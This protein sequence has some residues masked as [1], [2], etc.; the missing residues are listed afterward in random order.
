MPKSSRKKDSTRL[1]SEEAHER[2]IDRLNA[3][4][5]QLSVELA[6]MRFAQVEATALQGTVITMDDALDG[7]FE[8]PWD[9]RAERHPS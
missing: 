9:R 5:A 1:V 4:V 2:E 7:E 6:L 3:V 8:A